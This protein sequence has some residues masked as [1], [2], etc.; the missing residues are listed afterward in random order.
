[1]EAALGSRFEH[2]GS[3]DPSYVSDWKPILGLQNA[4]LTFG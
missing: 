4:E 1:M 3:E 2:M